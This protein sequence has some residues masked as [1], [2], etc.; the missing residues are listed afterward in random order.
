MAQFVRDYQVPF[1]DLSKGTSNN[2]QQSK[3]F[4]RKDDLA[5]HLWEEHNQLEDYS[6][7]SLP[8]GSVPRMLK[9]GKYDALYT[10]APSGDCRIFIPDKNMTVQWRE[11]ENAVE[12]HEPVSRYRERKFAGDNGDNVNKIFIMEHM[13][14]PTDNPYDERIQERYVRKTDWKE[15][16][17]TLKSIAE[18]S[19][20]KKEQPHMT[21]VQTPEAPPF[22]RKGKIGGWN[23]SMKKKKNGAKKGK[24]DQTDNVVEVA[25]EVLGLG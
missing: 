13:G 20:R 3:M 4:L 19:L 1:D 11:P 21:N 8:K 18:E 10:E 12:G 16:A 5:A 7:T 9:I 6:P 2:I 25:E 17:E 23:W 22:V 14:A 15:V 24:G